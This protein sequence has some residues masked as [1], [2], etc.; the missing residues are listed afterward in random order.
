MVIETNKLTL[1]C[2]ECEKE[3]GELEAFEFGGPFSFACE[4]CVRDYYRDRPSEIETELKCRRYSAAASIKRNRR[5]LE[6]QAVKRRQ[7]Q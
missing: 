5:I 2:Y 3:L 4:Q 7:Y 1:I 6:E